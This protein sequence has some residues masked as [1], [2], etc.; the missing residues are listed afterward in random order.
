[1]FYQQYLIEIFKY[2][3]R[4]NKQLLKKI[5]QL[6]QGLHHGGQV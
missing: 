2:N 6:Y 5:V 4:A 1:M 3:S